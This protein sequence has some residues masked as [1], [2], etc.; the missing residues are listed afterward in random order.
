M[1]LH[2]PLVNAPGHMLELLAKQELER[3]RCEDAAAYELELPGHK[4]VG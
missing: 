4:W 3:K 2:W 1:G